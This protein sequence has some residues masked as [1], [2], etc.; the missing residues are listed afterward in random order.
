MRSMRWLANNASGLIPKGSFDDVEA[1]A[2]KW[3]V[4]VQASVPAKGICLN[5]DIIDG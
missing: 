3:R 4:V 1:L 5:T 2:D